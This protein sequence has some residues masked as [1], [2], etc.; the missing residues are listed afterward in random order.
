[1]KLLENLKL[2][3]VDDDADALDLLRFVLELKGAEVI[4]AASVSEAWQELQNNRFD[5]L[6]SDLGMAGTD[7]FDL[8][9]RLRT[10]E[11]KEI[12]SLPA[13]ALTGYATA[14]DGAQVLLAGFQIHLPKPLDIEVLPTAV[15]SLISNRQS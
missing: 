4:S 10:S 14:E 6:I 2:L 15:L 11:N 9:R 7:G 1:M 3:V 13:I 5:L 12:A 8:I